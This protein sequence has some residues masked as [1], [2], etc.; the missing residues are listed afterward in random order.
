LLR[1]DFAWRL[2]G[3]KNHPTVLKITN[4]EKYYLLSMFY[5]SAWHTQNFLLIHVL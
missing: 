3:V 2:C 4:L 5:F 1:V